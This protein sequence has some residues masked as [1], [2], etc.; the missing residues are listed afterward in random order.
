MGVDTRAPSGGEANQAVRQLSIMMMMAVVV[1]KMMIIIIC[2]RPVLIALERTHSGVFGDCPHR[3]SVSGHA[4][5]AH[6]KLHVRPL[7]PKL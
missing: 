3:S 4:T 2:R 7:G 1:A 5:G 6:F